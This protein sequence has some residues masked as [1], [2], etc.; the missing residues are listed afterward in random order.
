M[1]AGSAREP[2]VRFVAG[3]AAV[4]SG[5]AAPQVGRQPLGEDH[6]PGK[7]RRNPIDPKARR[8]LQP[9]SRT[10]GDRFGRAR[11][12]FGGRKARG[13][14]EKGR[15]RIL[16]S[17]QPQ[18]PQSS[19]FDPRPAA[20]LQKQDRPK[21]KPLGASPHRAAR[22]LHLGLDPRRSLTPRGLHRP[23]R[24][25]LCRRTTGRRQA[26]SLGLSAG[27]HCRWV[28]N[29]LAEVR[30]STCW[31]RKAGL[32]AGGRRCGRSFTSAGPRDARFGDGKVAPGTGNKR[33]EAPRVGTLRRCCYCC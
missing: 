17:I 4:D 6:L 26:G 12:A 13:P 32:E 23:P 5:K 31:P 28:E 15:N 19:P 7:A 20:A 1:R 8:N 16:H 33:P 21:T 9:I 11:G 30:R 27:R 22:S 10:V 2:T 24:D 29:F 25:G 14:I 3:P 18:F